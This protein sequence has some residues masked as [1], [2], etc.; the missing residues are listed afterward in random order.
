MKTFIKTTFLLIGL[1][2]VI[3]AVESDVNATQDEMTKFNEKYL[4]GKLTSDMNDSAARMIKI[5]DI[6]KQKSDINLTV[7]QMDSNFSKIIEQNRKSPEANSIANITKSNSFK[8]SIKENKKLILDN[9][10]IEG[11]KLSETIDKSTQT[12]INN[13]NADNN[14]EHIF[15]VISTTMPD[16]EIKSYFSAVEGKQGITFVLRGLVGGL[17]KFEPTRS[18][19]EKLIKKHPDVKDDQ[20]VFNVS[21]EINPKITKKYN[22]E[23]VPAII[24]IKNYNGQLEE[25]EPTNQSDNEDVWISYGMASLDYIF[26]RINKEAKS[27]WLETLLKKETFFNEDRQHGSN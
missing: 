22:I 15:I 12:S 7:H 9:Y 23:K 6:A 18:Y 27:Q 10:S 11:K 1:A 13:Y 2:S 17:K 5:S 14:S 16:S 26:E 25:Y 21:L 8:E 20:E 24:Y 3:F 19:I 4:K